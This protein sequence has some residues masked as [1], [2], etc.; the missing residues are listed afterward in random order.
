[1]QSAP[2]VNRTRHVGSVSVRGRQCRY[3]MFLFQYGL[4]SAFMGCFVYCLMGTSRDI[5]MGPTAI[6]SIL[7]SEYAHDP[8]LPHSESSKDET[9]SYYHHLR[10][11]KPCL[12]LKNISHIFN[13]V[14]K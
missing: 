7:V 14:G 3:H 5:T 11:Y 2:A 12:M 6:M 1:M 4:Y 13:Y 9:V 8:W 10:K